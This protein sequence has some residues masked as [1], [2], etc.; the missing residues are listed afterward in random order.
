MTY[1]VNQQWIDWT[2][3]GDSSITDHALQPH[4]PPCHLLQWNTQIFPSILYSPTHCFNSVLNSSRHSL[5]TRRAYRPGKQVMSLQVFTV[6]SCP[7]NP[8]PP[9][10]PPVADHV[11]WP[12]S[13]FCPHHQQIT[14][15]FLF[16][17][18]SH[19]FCH[20]SPQLQQAVFGS[21][22]PK[23]DRQTS[24][25]AKQVGDL[26]STSSPP[27]PILQS[28]CQLCSRQPVEETNQYLI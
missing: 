27:Y 12:P 21:P 24:R 10:P 14:Q 7:P 22:P 4:L 6:P 9:L 13:R 3:F 23:C 15:I 5:G 25:P 8:I 26:H 16:K 17:L 1:R 28:Q 11:L 20:H 19:S 18:P 2:C